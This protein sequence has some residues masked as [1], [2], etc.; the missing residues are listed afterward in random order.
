MPV[1]EPTNTS[2]ST[3]TAMSATAISMATV[4]WVMHLTVDMRAAHDSHPRTTREMHDD[5]TPT[6]SI[7]SVAALIREL[8]AVQSGS[9]R[10]PV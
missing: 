5:I 8:R 6:R 7:A 10:H 2:R 9:N 4:G 1:L 3:I